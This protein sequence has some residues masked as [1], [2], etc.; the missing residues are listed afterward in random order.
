MLL[1]NAQMFES[2][3]VLSQAKG[4][5]GLLGYAVA[6]NLRKIAGEVGEFTKTRDELL[7]QHGAD[8]GNGRYNFTPAAAAAF[9]AALEPFAQIETDVAVMQVAPE[10]FYSGNLTSEQMYALSWMVKEE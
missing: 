7:A 1:T 10:V 8:A 6:V 3:Q 9:Q 4:E 5:K 2:V